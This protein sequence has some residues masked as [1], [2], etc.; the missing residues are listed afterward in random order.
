MVRIPDEYADTFKKGDVV[1]LIADVVG[2]NLD[3][4][5]GIT[6]QVRT[7]GQRMTVSRYITPESFD[8]RERP[9]K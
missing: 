1:N 2:I 8:L 3:G 5:G 9:K 6:V 4:N 7:T